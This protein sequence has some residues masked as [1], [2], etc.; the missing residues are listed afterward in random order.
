MVDCLKSYHTLYV[1][2]L[3]TLVAP[4]GEQLPL[5]A[6][7]F[8]LLLADVATSS[9]RLLV[10]WID[11]VY[12]EF[13]LLRQ[14]AT[15]CEGLLAAPGTPATLTRGGSPDDQWSF[16]LGIPFGF[17]VYGFGLLAHRTSHSWRQSLSPTVTLEVNLAQ[18]PAQLDG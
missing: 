15:W 11:V 14:P 9:A 18:R 3:G 1:A 12:L 4:L 13:V 16:G 5:A 7:F 17:R 2:S 6:A 10:A 8:P